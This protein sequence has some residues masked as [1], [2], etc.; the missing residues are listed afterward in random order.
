MIT[1]TLCEYDQKLLFDPKKGVR[2]SP[3]RATVVAMVTCCAA[4]CSETATQI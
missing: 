2:F 1:V 4:S 3:S